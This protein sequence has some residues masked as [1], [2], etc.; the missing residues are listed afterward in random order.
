MREYEPHVHESDENGKAHQLSDEL[1]ELVDTSIENR[2]EARSELA[3]MVEQL[4]EARE[5]LDMDAIQRFAQGLTL[6]EDVIIKVLARGQSVPLG[7][8]EFEAETGG[9]FSHKI[10]AAVVFRDPEM[11]VPFGSLYTERDLAHELGHATNRSVTDS[12]EVTPDAIQPTQKAG[13]SL[14]R[15]QA[16]REKRVETIRRGQF[17][18]EAY[19]EMVAGRYVQEKRGDKGFEDVEEGGWIIEYSE[20]GDTCVVKDL[21][22]EKINAIRGYYQSEGT[23]EP[24]KFVDQKYALRSEKGALSIAEPSS[25][26]QAIELIVQS[27]PQFKQHLEASRNPDT[28]A[29]GMRGAIQTLEG[30][31]KGLYQ[32]LARLQ[33]NESDFILGQKLVIDALNNGL[34]GSPEGTPVAL[35]AKLN[36]PLRYGG[37]TEDPEAYQTGAVAQRPARRKGPGMV[38]G[39]LDWFNK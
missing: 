16:D 28:V 37:D 21:T 32:K 18:E 34:G 25:A 26:A 29:E 4:P 39:L 24:L 2:R 12:L 19:A 33:Y 35:E 6:P 7:L 15:V 8:G 13:F 9:T 10:D 30:I 22:L 11:E 23:P 38:K 36:Q 17:F 27:Y 20:S 5:G 31:Q 14:E 1:R 3:E